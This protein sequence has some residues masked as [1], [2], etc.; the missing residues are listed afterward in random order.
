MV[1]YLVG[2]GRPEASSLPLRQLL[3]LWMQQ[4]DGGISTVG[5]KLV[6]GVYS[7]DSD[8]NGYPENWYDTK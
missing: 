2:S 3:V 4:F 7:Q 1:D 6:G 5:S 8:G